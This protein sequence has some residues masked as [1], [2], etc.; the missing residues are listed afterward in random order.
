MQGETYS[1]ITASLRRLTANGTHFKWTKECQSSFDKMKE[2]LRSD[3]VLGNYDPSKETRLYVDHGPKGVAATVTQ[4]EEEDATIQVGR[5]L[6]M[7]EK[8][9]RVDTSEPAVAIEQLQKAT[10]E[11]KMMVRLVKAVQTGQ[12]RAELRKSAY[13]QVLP[14]LSCVQGVLVR[15]ERVVVPD[16]LQA[17]VVTLAHKGHLGIEGTLRNLR[18]KVWFPT[19][20]MNKMVTDFVSTCLGC[21][22]AVPFNLL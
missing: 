7:G 9:D 5:L 8:V 1:D 10:S 4:R 17:A 22:A 11:D 16:S 19:N 3:V 2:M 14:E 12:G 6:M 21:T 18:D 15:V 13:E 20:T